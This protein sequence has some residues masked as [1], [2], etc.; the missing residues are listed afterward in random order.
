VRGL[1]VT[2]RGIA[3]LIAATAPLAAFTTTA[4]AAN[5][6][7][8]GNY[9]ATPPATMSF[10]NLD[11]SG[12]GGVVNTHGA[13]VDE[14]F[15]VAID[16]AGGTLFWVNDSGNAVSW[17]NLDGSRAGNLD[18]TGASAV[19]NPESVTIDPG[20]GLIY[21]VNGNNKIS[22]A[23]LDGTGGGGDLNTTGATVSGADGV[24]ID[25]VAGRIYWANGG[26]PQGI[27]FAKLDG[28]GGGGQLN[29]GAATFS[30]PVGLAIDPATQR[31]FWTNNAGNKISFA[32]LDGSGGGDLDTSPVTVQSPEGLAVDPVGGRVY[33]A[34]Y[35]ANKISFAKLD[36]TGGGGDLST[37][38]ATMD[39]PAYPALL[40]APAAAGAPEVGG[41]TSPGS[42]LS[43]TQ[44]AW[45]DD[46]L[47]SFTYRAPH[48]F[49]YQWTLNG[50]SV[51]GAESSSFTA[52]APGDY[53]CTVTASNAAGATS[54]T[55][56]VHTVAPPP[57]APAPPAPAP[58]VTAPL[59]FAAK[60]LVTLRLAAARIAARGPVRVRVTNRN[61][62]AVTGS[63][64][65]ATV[66]KLSVSKLR[67]V[68]LGA[69]RFSVAAHATRTVR[70][71]LPKLLRRVLAR[72]GKLELRLTARLADPSGHKRTVRK[73]VTLRLKPRR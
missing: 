70:L 34:N 23:K 67:R 57:E 12:G 53:R 10:A 64:S 25:R 47:G 73:Q 37:A 65:G 72:T 48:S 59:G 43:C 6:I 39:G 35:G 69:K 19:S 52:F 40:Y 61:G 42:V 26:V 49:G 38:G 62:F 11:G 28:T 54:Q 14:P 31:I 16:S 36:G 2:A 45:G 51:A 1:G 24:A 8:W 18:T 13:T 71:A 22:F 66:R 44:G 55:S 20:A 29:T 68:K 46:F 3:A 58:E 15:G 63:L 32:K 9:G 56:A 41:G 7:Y 27:F 33:W 50:E 21:W 5:R 4:A 30:G 60:T 17:A